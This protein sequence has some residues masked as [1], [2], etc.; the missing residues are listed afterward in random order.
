MAV[1]VKG[2]VLN[3]RIAYVEK[4]H[5]K[6]GFERV[7]EALSPEARAMVGGEILVSSWYP[8]QATVETLVTIDRL[9]GKG[10]L[11]LCRE[12]GRYTARAALAGGVQQSFVREHDPGFVI[13]MGPVI[14]R[15]YYDSGE[16]QVEQTGE[17]SAISRIVDFEEPHK[18]L[19]LSIQGW[20]EEAME[21]WGG[22]EIQVTETKC[23]TRG[24][25]CCEF[26]CSWVTP[27]APPPV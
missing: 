15:Q 18:V 5:G 27:P 1:H 4:Y 12:M 21:I 23:L 16:I 14:W 10:D 8:L 19:C 24:E 3:S 26:V 7:L 17:E 25:K 13:K 9:F 6:E 20:M 2:I 22:T 11:S